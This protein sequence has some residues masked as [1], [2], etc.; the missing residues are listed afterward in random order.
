M[1][2]PASG[3]D[4]TANSSCKGFGL[5]RTTPSKLA[6]SSRVSGNAVFGTQAHRAP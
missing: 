5:G 3:V 1:L 2:R 4:D 6:P